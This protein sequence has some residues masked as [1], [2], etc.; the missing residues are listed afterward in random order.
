MKGHAW[1][2]ADAFRPVLLICPARLAAF[3]KEAE[4][5]AAIIKQFH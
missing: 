1:T 2:T 3:L 4:R 5:L